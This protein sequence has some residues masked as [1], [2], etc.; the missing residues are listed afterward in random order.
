MQIAKIVVAAAVYAIDK[1]YD[2]LIPDTLLESC[3]PGVRM[4]VPFGHGNRRTEGLVLSTFEGEGEK[5]KAVESV[6]DEGPVLDDTMLRNSHGA[7]DK[8]SCQLLR[9]YR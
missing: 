8:G 6:L 5:L 9:W 4:V 7:P 1:P 2:Y 3:V